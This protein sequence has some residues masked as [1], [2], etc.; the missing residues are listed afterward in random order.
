[1]QDDVG[2]RPGDGEGNRAA[3]ALGCAGDEGAMAPQAQ[4]RGMLP[5]M[6]TGASGDAP[7]R[8]LLNVRAVSP[9]A[10]RRT[11]MALAGCRTR[12]R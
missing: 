8:V 3:Y 4:H 11:S 10:L 7:V 2:A 12:G 9:A 1:M 5:E 6:A